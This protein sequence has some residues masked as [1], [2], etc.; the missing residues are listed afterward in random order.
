MPSISIVLPIYNAAPYLRE[1]IDSILNQDFADFEIL[2]AN[3]GSTDGSLSI[4]LSYDDKRLHIFNYKHDYIQTLNNLIQESKGQYIARM[5]ADDIMLQ[6]RLS[7]QFDYLESHPNIDVLGGGMEFF[8]TITGKTQPLEHVSFDDMIYGCCMAH[9]TIMMRRSLFTTYKFQYEKDFIYAEDYRLWLQML[10]KGI[11]FRNLSECIIKYRIS[12]NQISNCK[13]HIQQKHAQKA[14]EDAINQK[15]II[16]KKVREEKPFIS[17]SSNELTVVIPFLNEGKEVRS[18]IESIIETIGDKVDIIVINDCSDDGYDYEKDLKEFHLI[19][20]RNSFRIGAASSKEKGVQLTTTPY[21][22]LLD[23]HMRFYDNQWAY[24][25]V[26]TLKKDERQLLCCQT[27]PLEKKNGVVRKKETSTTY[28]AFATFNYNEYIPGIRW[29][30]WKSNLLLK[31]NE[32]PCVLGAGY[33]ASKRYWN[34]LHGLQGLRHYGCEETF[35]SIKVWLEG[36]KC[37]LLPEITIGHIYR[38]TPPYRIVNTA[39]NF[40]YFVNSEILFPTSL[41]CWNHA[42]GNY[43]NHDLYILI[44]KQLQH[45]QKE[46]KKEKKYIHSISQRNFDFIININNIIS[47]EKANTAYEQEKRLKQLITFIDKQNSKYNDGLWSGNAARLLVLGLYAEYAENDYWNNKASYLLEKVCHSITNELPINLGNGLCG[48]G[49]TLLY[50]ITHNLIENNIE[51]ELITIDNLVQERSPLRTRD[52]SLRSG[53]GGILCYVVNRLSQIQQSNILTCSF[54]DEYLAELNES[55]HNILKSS[56]DFRCQSYALQYLARHQNNDN[57]WNILS[58]Q[59]KDIIDLPTFL[60]KSSNFWKRGLD[61]A[62]GYALHLI[63]TLENIKKRN[64]NL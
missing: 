7:K 31:G 8:G 1:C 16:E 60:P 32:I 52:L 23:A 4:L 9:P 37:R 3:D 49:W 38:H 6:G 33:A 50:L 40:N 27:A 63:I 13:K 26:N 2:A 57:E 42:I 61:A 5:D 45:Y 39:M 34:Y 55:A 30:R 18:T 19:Y 12:E 36:G 48:I 24:I 14:V 20:I 43:I 21:F 53:L 51:N 44:N 59:I 15:D 56:T 22:L 29:N 46:L 11:T 35:I 62:D 54:S 17:R 41:N 64:Y 47:P 25:I 58:P 28:G 10:L